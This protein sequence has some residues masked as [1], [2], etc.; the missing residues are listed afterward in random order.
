MRVS[1]IKKELDERGVSYQGLFEKSEFVD[2]LLDARVRGITAPAGTGDTG[3]ENQSR[4][5]VPG[6]AGSSDNGFDPVYKDVEVSVSVVFQCL[7]VGELI[8]P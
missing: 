8:V 7:S 6:A 2:L 4:D 5:G 3:D 1:Q